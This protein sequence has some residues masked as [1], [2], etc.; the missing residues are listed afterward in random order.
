[1]LSRN[2]VEMLST[3]VSR[4]PDQPAQRYRDQGQ[5]KSRSYQELWDIVGDVARG[6]SLL[7]VAPGDRVALISKTRPEWVIADFAIM[8]LGAVT[9]PIYPSVGSEQVKYILNDSGAQVIV[10]EDMTQCGKIPESYTVVIISGDFPGAKTLDWLRRSGAMVK[11]SDWLPALGAIPRDQLATIVYTSGTTGIPKGVMLSHGNLLSNI[12]GIL[13][14]GT[15]Y[16]KLRTGP[17]DT[18]LSFL[19]LSHVLERMAHAF[20]LHEG[21]T[22]AYAESVDALAEDLREI[23]PTI[24]IAVPRVFEKVYDRITGQIQKEALPKRAIF[25]WAIRQGRRRYRLAQTGASPKGLL[26]LDLAV[27]DRLVYKKLRNALGGRMRLIISG[28]APLAKEIGE[29]FYAAGIEIHE[30]YGLTETSP[31]LTVNQPGRV[32]YGTVGQAL[33]NVRLKI[34]HDGEILA[35]GPNVMQGYWKRPEETREALSEGWFHTGDIGSLTSDGVLTITDRKK[36]L[37]VLS[38][39]KKVAP[40]AVEQRLIL[41][42]Y[43]DQAVVLGDQRKYI[44]AL[45]YLNEDHVKKWATE[46]G[47]GHLSYPLLLRQSVLYDMVMSEVKRTT[48]RLDPFERPKKVAFLPNEMTEETGDL[49]PSLKV[50]LPVIQKK[51]AHLVESL[52]QDSNETVPDP[53]EEIPT[54]DESFKPSAEVRPM[55]VDVLGSLVLGVVFGLLLR[56][57]L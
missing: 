52:Y 11:S 14:L 31:V 19:P 29:F 27:A 45:V 1:M 50:K 32:L 22:I 16:E 39:G 54:S 9:V 6:L 25:N 42:P 46:H 21:V 18:A 2:L 7:G 47:L 24:L 15:R 10:A 44:T 34:A 4:Y 56:V 36:Y 53:Q 33:F 48:A 38:T 3:T 35:Q 57:I 13:E 5:W 17:E 43:I 49:T 51:Y 12:E 26:K 28:G 23:Q 20:L 8:S 37:I 41:S 55:V 30:G 40:S